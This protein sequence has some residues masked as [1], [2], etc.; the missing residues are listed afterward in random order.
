VTALLLRER[1]SFRTMA[2]EGEERGRAL[3]TVEKEPEPRVSRTS[4]SAMEVRRGRREG[5]VRVR[6]GGKEGGGKVGGRGRE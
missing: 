4:K 2:R 6:R 1:V 3:K 5:G